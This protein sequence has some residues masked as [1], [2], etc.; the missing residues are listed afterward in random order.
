MSEQVFAPSALG[1]WLAE[2][3][4]RTGKSVE[5][6][7]PQ[8][9][10][11]EEAEVLDC[12]RSGFVSTVGPRV[13]EFERALA[14]FT[15]A[16]YAIAVVN[17]TA[18]LH[19]SLL[20]AGVQAGEEVIVPALTF[21]ATANAVRYCGAA[22]CFADIEAETLG[23][24]PIR[25]RM[26]LEADFERVGDELRN[27]KTGRRVRALIAVHVFGNS[28]QVEGLMAVARDYGLVFIEDAAES[29]GSTFGK[30]HTGTFGQFG[31][32]SFNGNK[33]LTTGGGGAIL[34]DDGEVAARAKH[35]STQAKVPHRWEFRHDAVAFNYRMPNLN[36][37]LGLAQLRSLPRILEQKRKLAAW[38]GR[39]LAGF[40]GLEFF[41]ASPLG[42]SN[43]W[44]NS[45]L[46][47]PTLASHRDEVLQAAHER[48]V[49]LRPAWTVLPQ[50][51]IFAD[52]PAM[53]IPV[54]TDIQNRLIN[55]PSS[56]M[57]AEF[58]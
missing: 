37:A 25:L 12:V 45:V 3:F 5:L 33:I 49:H 7:E 38:Y 14:D 39:E 22:P 17:G 47:N 51:E 15:G 58:L 56:P 46:L 26:A 36:A 28:C 16:K 54:A 34:T 31:T 13:A 52:C 48:K 18:A 50:L 29:L 4:S 35:L 55:L 32:L 53:D 19:L 42:A 9:G 2:K 1:N 10:A 23:M 8:L 20:L 21:V 6:H 30:Q 40:P 41:E 44:L 11:A 43:R 24:D 57:L 27:R